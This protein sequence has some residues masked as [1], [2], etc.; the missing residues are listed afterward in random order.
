MK[1]VKLLMGPMRVPFL[2]L[3]PAC[4]AVGLGTAYR[5]IGRISLFHAL[6]VCI[7]AL[8]GHVCVNAFNEYFDFKSGLDAK[9]QRTPFSGGS[10]TLPHHPE[11]E[12]NTLALSMVTFGIVA[13]VGLYFYPLAR[14]DAIAHRRFRAV[15]ADHLYDLVDPSFGP[16]PDRTRIGFRYLHGHGDPLCFD[17]GL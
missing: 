9:T 10:G 2:M 13:V 16:V 12:K 15:F 14:L 17:R 8:A 3:T 5:Q 6:L 7:G 4:V 11:M 1:T